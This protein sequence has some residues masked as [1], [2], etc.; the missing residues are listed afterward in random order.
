M[1][2]G[3][4]I[5]PVEIKLDDWFGF[6]YR[7]INQITKQEY[8]GKKQFFSTHRKII[9]GKKNRKK[10]LKESDWKKYK[11]SSELVK[12][13][14]LIYG[15]ENFSFQIEGLYKTKGDLSYAEVDLQI[16][17]NV[18]REKLPNGINKYYN[19]AIGNIKWI[20]GEGADHWF[21][22][23]DPIKKKIYQQKYHLGRNN[24]VCR[25][26]SDEEWEQYKK[27]HYIGESNPMFG[28]LGENH[29]NFG[30]ILSEEQRLA[31]SSK[32][33]GKMVGELNPRY[34]K[35]PF[36]YFTD[37]ELSEHKR[38]LSVRMSGE[39]N[40]MFG[41]PC[42]YKM[43]EEEKET[44]KKNIGNSS[45]GRKKSDETKKRMSAAK[46]G[47]K[48]KS[49]TCPHCNLTGGGGNMSRYHFDKCKLKK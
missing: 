6:T 14:I 15:I 5:F 21:N 10:I 29:H 27:D 42:H 31:I 13:E 38:K 23:M 41:R 47:I 39:N 9:K 20:P 37:E 2:L 25:G 49:I 1:D 33:K 3:H 43:T 44:W 8:I 35:S 19:R 30:R 12:N 46:M 32:L 36:E 17:E 24:N 16:K 4:W 28:I 45:R 34:G 7:I 18:L 22:K 26:K 40:P 11:S 48:F